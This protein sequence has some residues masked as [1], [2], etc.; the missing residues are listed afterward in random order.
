MKL[1]TI[2]LC[3][4]LA[5]GNVTCPV[6]AAQASVPTEETCYA[7]TNYHGSSF[8]G[9]ETE[10]INY[11]HKTETDFHIGYSLPKYVDLAMDAHTNCCASTAGSIVM[12]YYD[13]VYDELIPG[14]TAGRTIRGVYIYY[15][16]N[17]VVQQNAIDPLY[18]A[19]KTNVY[20]AGTRS[21]DCRNGLKEV[22]QQRGRSCSFTSVVNN[23]TLNV[24]A[25][26][27]E[28]D[29]E[30]PVLFF[31]ANYTLLSQ[32][33]FENGAGQDKLEKHVYIGAH[34]F[35]GYGYK[36]V[37]YYD[38]A[39]TLIDSNCFLYAASGIADIQNCFILLNEGVILDEGYGVAIG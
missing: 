28:T 10:Y 31:S 15:G 18:T 35:V 3:G 34:V 11:H 25:Y 9:V 30:R 6:A 33:G 2:L 14:F 37:D 39:G 32:S 26:Q 24:A 17:E 8:Q 7:D 21:I 19:M 5:L 27:A 38:A 23:S 12:G 1:A 22:V 13:R 4:C 16:V 20:G 36:R 29:A